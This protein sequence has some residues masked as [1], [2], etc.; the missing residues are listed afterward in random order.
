MSTPS[1]TLTPIARTPLPPTKYFE[2]APSGTSTSSSGFAN[3]APPFGWRMPT[4]WNGMP[5]IWMVVPTA[6]PPRPRLL[7]TELPRTTV[8]S[9][10]SMS[11]W[12][13]KVP[14]QTS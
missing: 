14:C 9:D 13:R 1:A 4:T 6:S 11:T 7:A 5:S 3:P 2:T 8:R 12:L 10:R